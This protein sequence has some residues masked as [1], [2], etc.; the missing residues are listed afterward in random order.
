MQ[1]RQVI[2]PKVF[3]QIHRGTVLHVIEMWCLVRSLR[4]ADHPRWIVSEIWALEQPHFSIVPSLRSSQPEPSYC[5]G[6]AWVLRTRS[7]R[8]SYSAVTMKKF[9]QLESEKIIKN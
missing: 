1:R 5:R 4:L 7:R 9:L 3:R 8:S 2:L 6:D